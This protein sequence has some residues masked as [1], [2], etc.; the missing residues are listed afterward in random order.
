MSR[1]VALDAEVGNSTYAER[2]AEKHPE[3]FFEMFIAE[4]QLVA[5]AVGLQ[6]PWMEAVCLLLWRLS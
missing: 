1:V 4:Q 3:Q 6:G 5:A 2:F